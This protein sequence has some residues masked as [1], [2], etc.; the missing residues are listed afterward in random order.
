MA[1]AS[2]KQLGHTGVDCSGDRIFT[3]RTAPYCLHR[4]DSGGIILGDV[5]NYR[6]SLCRADVIGSVTFAW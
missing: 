5:R 1:A 4:A 3:G 2:A 6:L